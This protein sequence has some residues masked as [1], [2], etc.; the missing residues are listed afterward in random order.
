MVK[1]KLQQA[2]S[3]LKIL[4]EAN[5]ILEVKINTYVNNKY[6][7]IIYLQLYRPLAYLFY[8]AL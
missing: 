1:L 4:T 8:S 5:D 2:T 3:R 7:P 6:S